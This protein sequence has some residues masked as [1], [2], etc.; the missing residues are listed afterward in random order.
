M[1]YCVGSIMADVLIFV[2][3]RGR[4]VEQST[5]ASLLRHDSLGQHLRPPL[6]HG[7]RAPGDGRGLD[8]RRSFPSPRYEMPGNVLPS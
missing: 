5:H 2:F 4:L 7:G 3:D 8:S 1:R 6:A